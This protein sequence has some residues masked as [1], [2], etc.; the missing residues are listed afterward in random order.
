MDI[1]K[2]KDIEEIKAFIKKH[3]K[4]LK[5]ITGNVVFILIL[6]IVLSIVFSSSSNSSYDVYY[7]IKGTS[8]YYVEK[9]SIR[10]Y[11]D[12]NEKE[13]GEVLYFLVTDWIFGPYY[14][15]NINCMSSESKLVSSFYYDNTAVLNFGGGFLSDITSANG[16]E[17]NFIINSLLKSLEDTFDALEYVTIYVEDRFF[18]KYSI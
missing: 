5:V 17:Q 6:F 4:I 14:E 2:Y 8:E 11:D 16:M 12:E 13:L 15:G 10:D 7:S 9:H 1:S 3:N 18:G